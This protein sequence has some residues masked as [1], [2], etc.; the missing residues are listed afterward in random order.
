MLI[1]GLSLFGLIA[2]SFSLGMRFANL[3]NNRYNK[4]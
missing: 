3:R 2:G 4:R 1:L